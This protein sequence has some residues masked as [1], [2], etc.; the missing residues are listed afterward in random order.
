MRKKERKENAG[1]ESACFI[2]KREGEF[3]HG[4]D[5]LEFEGASYNIRFCPSCGLGKTFPFL[6]PER[7]KKIY[8]STYRED[9]STRFPGPLE[10]VINIVR[11]GRCRRVEALAKKG[12]VLDIGCGRADFLLLM[13]G[14]GW[15]A[16]GLELDERIKERGGKA[17][18]VELK[19]GG[20]EENRFPDAF[21]DAVTLWHV[22]EHLS[23]PAWAL[24]ECKRILKPGGTLVIAVPNVKSLQAR[25][26]GKHWFHFD[27][28][29]HLYHYS[30]LNLSR[31]LEASSFKVEKVRH[32]SFEYNPF[33][34]LQSIFNRMGFR[35]NLFYDFLRSR[36]RGTAE[37]YFCIAVMFIMMPV[38]LPLSI[39]LSIA[40]ALLRQGGTIEVY[41]R[42]QG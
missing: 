5:G 14:R 38:I 32:F 30:A 4:Y 15:E 37:D 28:P 23:D 39:L 18:G 31:L 27:P 22:F 33:G 36:H 12:R 35:A 41:A 1:R 9:D 11:T 3:K 6:S 17:R 20:L 40:E 21:F 24:G 25:M 42:K 7:L 2:C 26:T 34:F 19:Y 13:K 10:A 8:S 16:H 29:F